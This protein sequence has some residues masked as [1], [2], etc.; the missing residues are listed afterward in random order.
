MLTDLGVVLGLFAVA[1]VLA[2]VLWTV[3]AA[4]VTVVRLEAGTASDELALSH[5]ISQDGWYAV[6]AGLGGL[7]LGVVCMA[8]RRT[9]EVVTLLGVLAGALLAALLA[10]RVG[11]FLG[12]DD[13]D[14]VLADSAIGSTAPDMLT[15]HA[16]G[17][18]LVWPIAAMAG[19]LVVL[20]SGPGERLLSRGHRE[21]S[22]VDG[23]LDHIGSPHVSTT[24]P[25][26]PPPRS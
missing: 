23:D 2:G 5:R 22:P 19:A 24:D 7:A 25:T 12:P 9:H 6:L 8:W 16:D 1:G 26:A 3:L 20:W 13:P 14:A 18:Y 4:P 15:V 21:T 17:A 10:A 11:G